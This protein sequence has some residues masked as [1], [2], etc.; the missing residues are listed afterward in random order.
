VTDPPPPEPEIAELDGDPAS[1]A[2]T[3]PVVEA[4]PKGA[5]GNENTAATLQKTDR[6]WPRNLIG[7]VYDR[8]W[9]A[10]TGFKRLDSKPLDISGARSA[11]SGLD[12][13]GAAYDRIGRFDFRD[14]SRA[15]MHGSG[16]GIDSLKLDRS[17][18]WTGRF[19]SDEIFEDAE[20][21][22][23]NSAIRIE[24][25]DTGANEDAV[26]EDLNRPLLTPLVGEKADLRPD[27][28]QRKKGRVR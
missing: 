4:Q 1:T 8:S 19:V 23:V 21:D 13:S 12:R 16:Y 28:A 20:A 27:A 10:L 6:Y 18:T 15:S 7:W 22:D 2:Q 14:G 3:D 11:D 26:L 17:A 9:E 24:L 25:P 5:A